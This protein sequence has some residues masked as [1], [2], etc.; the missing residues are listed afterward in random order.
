MWVAFGRIPEADYSPDW[1]GN[2]SNHV[3]DFRRGRN[4]FLEGGHSIN[5]HPLPEDFA[6][7]GINVDEDKYYSGLPLDYPGFDA[8]RID[9]IVRGLEAE[10]ENHPEHWKQRRE[11]A[12]SEEYTEHLLQVFQTHIDVAK[13]KVFLALS[14]AAIEAE[15]FLDCGEEETHDGDFDSYLRK[16]KPN[17]WTLQGLVW[18]SHSLKTVKEHFMVVYL[19]LEDVVATFPEPMG[20]KHPETGERHKYSIVIS[21]EG[22]SSSKRT[23]SRR[24]SA[25]RGAPQ[26]GGGLLNKAAMAEIDRLRR[27]GLL[28]DKQEAIIAVVIEY[29]ARLGEEVSRSTVQR[30]I[31]ARK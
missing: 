15:G 2:Y 14:S 19:K 12:E 1:D 22:A 17:D 21:G 13:S 24:P 10:G 30:W 7:L 18:E 9:S 16:I 31:N 29:C 3:V 11:E 5:C 27:E 4:C 8:E 23:Q 20:V 28:P 6:A 26:K 25:P